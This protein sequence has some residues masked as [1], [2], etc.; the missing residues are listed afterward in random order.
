MFEVQER[1]R[2][3]RLHIKWRKD[4]GVDWNVTGEE[5]FSSVSDVCLYF[6]REECILC[7]LLI[8]LP[9]LCGDVVTFQ[10]YPWVSMSW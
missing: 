3:L 8:F 7:F 1:R 2:V 10:L 4:S 5:G 6:V 9:Q